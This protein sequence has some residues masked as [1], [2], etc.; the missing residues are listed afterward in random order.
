MR[1][2]TVV[3]LTVLQLTG[4]PPSC[5]PV[6]L[7]ECACMLCSVH[8][9]HVQCCAKQLRPQK[10]CGPL[11]AAPFDAPSCASVLRA[12]HCSC[13]CWLQAFMRASKRMCRQHQMC[14][15]ICRHVVF[16]CTCS[17][18]RRSSATWELSQAR[19]EMSLWR[20]GSRLAKRCGCSFRGKWNYRRTFCMESV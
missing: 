18:L 16:V 6:H 17:F 11:G 15:G 8:C 20:R 7:P 9:A 14:G 2:D 4:L 1:R 12:Q 10:I 3:A 13:S 5:S 19:T